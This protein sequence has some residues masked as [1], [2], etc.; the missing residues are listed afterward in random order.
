MFGC[1]G[2]P[3]LTQPGKLNLAHYGELIWLAY[4][5]EKKLVYTKIKTAKR[6][7]PTHCFLQFLLVG[8]GKINKCA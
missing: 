8:G 5:T 2:L 1:G 6:G 4:F 3:D 7:N